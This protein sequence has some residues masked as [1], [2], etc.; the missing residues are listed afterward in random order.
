M[1]VVFIFTSLGKYHAQINQSIAQ[2]IIINI[3]F[4]VIIYIKPREEKKR[5]KI[6][7]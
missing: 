7:Y 4:S 1:K 3:L 2:S 6:T 5:K